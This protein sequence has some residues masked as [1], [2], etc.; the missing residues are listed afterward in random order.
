[1][2]P[3]SDLE[4][5]RSLPDLL[6]AGLV[7]FAVQIFGDCRDRPI[8]LPLA[9]DDDEHGILTYVLNDLA[10]EVA[11]AVG[12]LRSALEALT[13]GDSGTDAELRSQRH[14]VLNKLV[15]DGGVGEAG[16]ARDFFKGVAFCIKWATNLENAR[17]RILKKLNEI[18]LKIWF[19]YCR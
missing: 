19:A 16:Y 4:N 18:V 8:C 6:V 14:S 12:S 11:K 5:C 2:K 17:R 3:F 10:C 13:S 1:M 15:L 7:A 9:V